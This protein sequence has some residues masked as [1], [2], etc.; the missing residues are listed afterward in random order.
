MKD[1]NSAAIEP[2]TFKNSVLKY[3]SESS[4]LRTGEV[5]Y[6]FA[7][8]GHQFRVQTMRP[9]RGVDQI[10][11]PAESRWKFEIVR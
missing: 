10:I 4:L 7:D 3:V 8:E 1:K 2:T 9:V 5:V 6:C 11:F